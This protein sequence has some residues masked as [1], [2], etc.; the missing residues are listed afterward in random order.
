MF[1]GSMVA[2]VTPM[3]AQGAID[4]QSFDQLLAFHLESGTD[5]L[6]INGTTAESPSLTVEERQQTLKRAIDYCQRKIPIIAGTGSNDTQSSI[7]ASL[8]AKRLGADATLLVCPYYNKPTQQGLYAHFEK[9]AQEVALPHILYNVPGRTAVDLENST[10]L[11]LSAI[12]NIVGIKDATGDLERGIDLINQAPK[13]F[14]V[15]SGDDVTALELMAAGAQ[16]SISVTANLVPR[17]LKQVSDC[18]LSGQL[19]SARAVNDSL[20]PL[21]RLLFCE[22][23]PIPV[24]WAL[25]R[26]GKIQPGIRLPLTELSRTLQPPL[27]Q[28]LRELGLIS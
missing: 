7:Q 25:A 17:H 23:N 10:L 26:M 24:K 15:L 11:R 22:S 2:L 16:G 5:A 12:S 3:D 6:V 9:I 4:W 13:E 1:T 21:H 19:D 18:L 14:V 27:T 28:V 20:M 8:E